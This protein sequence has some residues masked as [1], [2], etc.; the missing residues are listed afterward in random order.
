MLLAVGP[1]A[2]VFASV[3]PG[4]LAVP[5]LLIVKVLSLIATAVLPRIDSIAIHIVVNP[6]PFIGSSIRPQV[7]SLHNLKVGKELTFPLI[8]LSTHCPEY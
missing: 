2:D 7:L 6:L 1:L 3:G 4:V 5:M 8:L